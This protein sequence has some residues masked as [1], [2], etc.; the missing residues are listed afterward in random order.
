MPG[1]KAVDIRKAVSKFRKQSRRAN[2]QLGK[3]HRYACCGSSKSD[4]RWVQ[5]KVKPLV[6]TYKGRMGIEPTRHWSAPPLITSATLEVPLA[7]ALR[8]K[9]EVGTCR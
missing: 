7:G 4:N 3:R 1:A 9:L 6:Y 2:L 8:G 5:G